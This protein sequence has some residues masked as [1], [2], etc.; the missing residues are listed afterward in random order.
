MRFENDRIRNEMFR[1]ESRSGR[2]LLAGRLVF[3]TSVG[4]NQPRLHVLA[5][6]AAAEAISSFGVDE[7]F[8]RLKQH[9]VW[10]YMSRCL[11]IAIVVLVDRLEIRQDV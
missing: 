4:R 5:R 2:K 11:A 6:E 10:R 3:G 1:E 9:E 7:L 8:A